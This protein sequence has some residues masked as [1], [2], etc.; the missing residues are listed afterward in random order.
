MGKK[1]LCC[2]LMLDCK[3]VIVLLSLSQASLLTQSRSLKLLQYIQSLKDTDW[4][5]IYVY[6]Y[7]IKQKSTKISTKYTKTQ[8]SYP[9]A[10]ICMFMVKTIL[11]KT[12]G[13]DTNSSMGKDQM[14]SITMFPIRLKNKCFFSATKSATKKFPSP[15]NHFS[16]F[17]D[18]HFVG[19]FCA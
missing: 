8:T 5:M 17:I 15:L 13:N 12:M 7:I 6:Y 19:L 16:S 3:I 2:N 9:L 18:T 1:L 10:A 14:T 11:F 4:R